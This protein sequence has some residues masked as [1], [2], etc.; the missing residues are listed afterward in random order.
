MAIQF[1]N[2]LTSK[3]ETFKPI[4]GNKVNIFVCG[5]TVYDHSHIGHLKTYMGFDVIVKYLR[6][7]KYN[8]Y[9]LQNITDLDDKIINRAK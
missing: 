3:R 9:Y 5:P 7:S 6:Y 8:V 2:T 4:K 1:Y